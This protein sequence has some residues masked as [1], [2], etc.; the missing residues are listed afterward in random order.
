V[1]EVLEGPISEEMD[2]ISRIRGR[3]LK[4]NLT[5]W[6]NVRGSHGTQYLKEARKPYVS[7]VAEV[8][9]EADFCNDGMVNSRRLAV[10]EIIEVIEGP[11][12]DM[13]DVALRVR[14]RSCIDGTIGWFTLR[15]KDGRVNAAEGTRTYY[16]CRSAGAITDSIGVRASK[17]IRKLEVNEVFFLLDGPVTETDMNVVRVQGRALK[18]Q[19]TGWITIRGNAGT[20]YATDSIKYVTMF[21]DTPMHETFQ[22][23]GADVKR[24]LLKNEA[25]EVLEDAKEETFD[26]VFRLRGR[27]LKD[28]AV[29]WISVNNKNLK[30]W[31][32]LYECIIA[33]P[34]LDALSIKDAQVVRQVHEGETVELLEGPLEEANA[35][36]IRMKCRAEKD[37]MVGWVTTKN[38]RGTAFFTSL[39]K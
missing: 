6:I 22:S 2:G 3:A 30:P 20:E 38:N 11:R 12:K 24:V 15:D 18:D 7:V 29:G 39:L 19:A 33:V 16:T 13:F 8:Q 1:V 5:G 23:T 27:A 37:D 34:L 31:T 28:G 10:D 36:L 32:P 14:G 26:T 17:V 4:D 25:V 35:G 9:L 21:F